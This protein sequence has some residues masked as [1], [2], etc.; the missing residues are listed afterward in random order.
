VH[1]RVLLKPQCLTRHR[2]SA[3]VLLYRLYGVMVTRMTHDILPEIGRSA[4]R[5]SSV[6]FVIVFD[7][8][9]VAIT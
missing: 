7:I 3:G 1:T 2:D 5:I 9:L 6:V 4:V 8:I